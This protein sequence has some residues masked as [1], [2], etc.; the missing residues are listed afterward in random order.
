MAPRKDETLKPFPT[1]Y[2][3]GL[4]YE[5]EKEKEGP[6]TLTL[7]YSYFSYLIKKWWTDEIPIPIPTPIRTALHNFDG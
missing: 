2:N 5:Y 3:A 4:E 1:N 6:S 7:K